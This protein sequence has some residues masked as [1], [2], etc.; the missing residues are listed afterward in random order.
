MIWLVN[1]VIHSSDIMARCRPVSATHVVCDSVP[2]G[3]RPLAQWLSVQEGDVTPTQGESLFERGVRWLQV[4]FQF[5]WILRFSK[6][7]YFKIKEYIFLENQL[8]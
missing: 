3:I 2:R 6:Q 1:F 8:K 4:T 5:M 7:E